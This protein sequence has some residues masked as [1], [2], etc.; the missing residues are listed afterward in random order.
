[1]ETQNTEKIRNETN[2]YFSMKTI[3]WT[4]RKNSDSIQCGVS[5][6]SCNISLFL[7]FYYYF[8]HN[9]LADISFANYI[10]AIS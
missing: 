9:C 5:F 10:K 6:K 1:M 2:W 3:P 8:I 7:L 4:N